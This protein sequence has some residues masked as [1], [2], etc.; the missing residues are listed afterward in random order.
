MRAQGTVAWSATLAQYSS[1]FA[2][3]DESSDCSAMEAHLADAVEER[4]PVVEMHPAG[5]D[6]M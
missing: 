3:S 5:A 4:L 6:V 2:S 1:F